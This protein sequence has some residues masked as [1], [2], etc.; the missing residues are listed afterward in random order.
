MK[1]QIKAGVSKE[2]V[3]K[4]ATERAN[5]KKLY[6]DVSEIV[7]ILQDMPNDQYDKLG[8]SKLYQVSLDTMQTI[9]PHVKF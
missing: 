2:E 1:R 4:Q 3:F 5:M 6:L 7:S 9:Y 8:L